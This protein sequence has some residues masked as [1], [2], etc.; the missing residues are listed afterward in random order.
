M[1]KLEIFQSLWAMTQLRPDG[2]EWPL[3]EQI[4]MIADAG[5][6]GVDL[7]YGDFDIDEIQPL[8]NNF[9]LGSTITAFP[10][11]IEALESST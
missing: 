4:E 10:D 11:S 8:L 5:F 2:F 3:Q 1:Q 7:V 6:D 9:D